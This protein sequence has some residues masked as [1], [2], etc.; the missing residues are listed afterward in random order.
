MEENYVH[1]RKSM[2]PNGETYE[3]GKIVSR[4]YTCSKCK[5]DLEVAVDGDNKNNPLGLNPLEL[6]V[7]KSFTGGSL[8]SV[9]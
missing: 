9:N 6:R 2:L 3:D 1:C 4:R 8:P 7:I 5:Y